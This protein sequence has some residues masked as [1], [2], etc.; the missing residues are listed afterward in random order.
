M[1]KVI[2]KRRP[3]KFNYHEILVREISERVA[4]IVTSEIMAEMGD[5]ICPDCEEQIR[6]EQILMQNN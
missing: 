5:E 3:P 6:N 1:H 4:T 2:R